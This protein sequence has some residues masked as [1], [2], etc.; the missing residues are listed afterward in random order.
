MPLRSNVIGL[1]SLTSSQTIGGSKMGREKEKGRTVLRCVS[2][3]VIVEWVERK[4]TDR[5]DVNS[6]VLFGT[7][8][9]SMW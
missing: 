3:Y 5:P 2:V 8:R 1:I 6:F 9:K 4:L 7:S